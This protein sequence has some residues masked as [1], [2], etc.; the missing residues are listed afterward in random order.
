[1]SSSPKV[2]RSLGRITRAA[3]RHHKAEAGC[4][5]KSITTQPYKCGA[6]GYGRRLPCDTDLRSCEPGSALV[7][8]A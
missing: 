7:G 8:F 1:M 4:D 5:A 3:G 2:R 6:T